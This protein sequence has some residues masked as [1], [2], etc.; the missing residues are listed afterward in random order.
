MRPKYHILIGLLFSLMIYLFFPFVGL[1]GIGLIFFSSF[2]IDFD[3]YAYYCIK[4]R[5]F[6]PRRAYLG[7]LEKG[8]IVKNLPKKKLKN[9]YTGIEIFHGL[10]WV[11][12]FSLLGFYLSNM[13]YFIALGM[14]LHLIL[15]WINQMRSSIYPRK[16]SVI[17]D[18]IMIK[19]KK[20][21]D[22]F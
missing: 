5:D 15:D 20:L 19:R 13:F 22:C 14:F 1:L 16:F 8:K 21:I 2:L 12:I 7:F 17:H 11:L 9:F 10:E 6:S 3:H 18:L 4:R